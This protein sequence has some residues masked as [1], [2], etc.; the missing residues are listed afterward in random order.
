[1]GNVSRVGRGVIDVWG[2]S[3]DRPVA[4]I[5]RLWD[6]LSEEE[7]MRATRFVKERDA[8]RFTA[9]RATLRLI[10]GRYLRISPYDLVLKTNAYG[11]PQVGAFSS[12]PLQFNLS[13]SGHRA[14]L[15]VCDNYPIGIDIEEIKPITEDVAAHFFSPRE[16]AQ[17]KGLDEEHYIPGFYR[18]WTR[19]E[20]FVKA[21]GAGLSLPLAC[22][23]VTIRPDVPPRLER[24][25]GD[26]HAAQRWSLFDLATA[27]GF[28]GA[29]AA[30]TS[31]QS[32]Q[33][34]YQSMDLIDDAL[35]V[36]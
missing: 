20:A 32:A 14:V 6:L 9:G 15:A 16:C 11:K 31:G 17:L 8:M 24:L 21:H 30:M 2:W 3:L 25:E 18:C 4:E 10:L 12:P 7:A 33:L 28:T 23:D 13:H 36:A 35:S 29:V 19:K 27:P 22:F 26:P 1:M 5:A 34:Q